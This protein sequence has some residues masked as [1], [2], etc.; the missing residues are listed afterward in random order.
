MFILTFGLSL[1]C[2]FLGAELYKTHR[3][4][5]TLS[6]RYRRLA[7][8]NHKLS[9]FVLEYQKENLLML[10]EHQEVQKE[11]K[12]VE[13][14]QAMECSA[15]QVVLPKSLKEYAKLGPEPLVYVPPKSK[16]DELLDKIENEMEV[17]GCSSKMYSD[18]E[19]NKKFEGLS[20][21]VTLE[22]NNG[23]IKMTDCAL[24]PNWKIDL[25][26]NNVLF[27]NLTLEQNNRLK[28]IFTNKMAEAAI[29][30]SNKGIWGPEHF[31]CEQ[32]SP[33]IYTLKTNE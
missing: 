15:R 18:E 5:S 29:R 8:D 30:D 19:F 13:L 28:V 6:E 21:L 31:G 33:G 11:I 7:D 26:Y 4:R 22:L 2:I 27:T 23:I 1:L 3:I 17:T 9:N 25:V 16:V 14:D 24:H 20:P 32:I 12:E 10:E